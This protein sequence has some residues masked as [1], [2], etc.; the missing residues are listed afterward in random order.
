MTQAVVFVGSKQSGKD[1]SCEALK[2]YIENAM[3]K[4]A[5]I[6][7]FATP[8]KKFAVDVFGLKPEWVWGTDEDKNTE[9]HLKWRDLPLSHDQLLR[10]MSELSTPTRLLNMNSFLTGREFLQV[11]GT[12]ICRAIFPPCWSVATVNS[13]KNDAPDYALLCDCRFPDELA[14]LMGFDPI[15]VRLLRSPFPDRHTSE[16]AL[17]DFDWTSL[18]TFVIDN[19]N[20]SLD[21]KNQKVITLFEST[22]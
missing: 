6:F 2:V 13:I 5:S 1:T 17:K 19:Q 20:I 16:N 18:H 8:L 3:G 10:L 15:I 21:E 14:S 4:T 7:A 9:T 11:F 12:D 22:L